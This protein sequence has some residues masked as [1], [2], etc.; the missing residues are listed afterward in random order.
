MD[1]GCYGVAAGRF[2]FEADPRRVVALVDRD[3]EFGTDRLTTVI[4]DFGE[5]RQLS[6]AV[7]TQI[8]G[9]Q[10]ATIAGTAGRIE[11]P[12]AFN[13]PPTSAATIVVDDGS[14]LGGGS[15]KAV[16]F[17]PVD[18][19]AEEADTFALAVLGDAPLPY[20]FDDA[21][22]NMQVL[23]AIFRSE[24]SGHWEATGL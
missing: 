23:D 19:Y 7:G 15:S 6:F 5:G 10:H 2:V 12:V 14:I 1:V 21:V 13:P 3:P 11:L 17:A 24:K 9:Y 18:Q 4:A 16:S 8:S 20:S 22:K